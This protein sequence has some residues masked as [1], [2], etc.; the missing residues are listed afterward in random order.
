MIPAGI[1]QDPGSEIDGLQ[2]YNDGNIDILLN[3]LTKI[4]N[5]GPGNEET[6]LGAEGERMDMGKDGRVGAME[7]AFVYQRG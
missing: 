4:Y 1:S 3:T 2:R 7:A 5:K 6:G